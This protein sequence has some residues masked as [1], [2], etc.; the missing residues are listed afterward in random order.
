[1]IDKVNFASC[2]QEMALLLGVEASGEWQ[3]A[4]YKHIGNYFDDNE[5]KLVCH[6]IMANDELYG[7][8]PTV[9]D[10]LKYAVKEEDVQIQKKTDFL[11]KVSNYLQL[12]YVSHWDKEEFNKDMTDLEYRTLQS[13]GGISELWRRV[14]NLDYPANISTI[15]KEL[16]DFY[17]DNYTSND[18][19]LAL[20]RRE[21]VGSISDIAKQF[22]ERK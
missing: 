14:H 16:G 15:R 7:K 2:I 12:D 11:N 5:F 8:M 9:K 10:F 22:L 17:D 21:S 13:A 3:K 6:K 1:M 19:K 18:V 20:K 4:M